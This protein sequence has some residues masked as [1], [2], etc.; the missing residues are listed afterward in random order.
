MYPVIFEG[1]I[2]GYFITIPSYNLFVSVGALLGILSNHINLKKIMKADSLVNY[3]FLFILSGLIGSKVFYILEDFDTFMFKLNNGQIT[4]SKGFVVF[5]SLIFIICSSIFFAKKNKI[6]VFDLLN[7]I[8]N[9]FIIGQ[10]IGRI[11]CFMAGCCY[12]LETKSVLGVTYSIDSG[13]NRPI[14]I[15]LHPTQLYE[16]FWLFFIFILLRF[17]M[18]SKNA[19]LWYISLYCF[20]R[21]FIEFLRGDESRGLF[22]NNL[23]SSSQIYSFTILFIILIFLILS[24]K[25]YSVRFNRS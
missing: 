11:G 3:H 14:N 18:F 10:I 8:T 1:N 17:K 24:K 21:F 9:G 2:F 6:K 23:F 7:G 22:F 5:G 20:G 25:L 15:P 13:T 12:G 19:F 4:F 16:V